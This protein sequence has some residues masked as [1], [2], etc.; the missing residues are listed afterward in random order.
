MAKRADLARLAEGQ[1]LDAVD[2]ATAEAAAL[3]ASRLVSVQPLGNGWLVTAGHTV[4]AVRCG[5]LVVRVRPKLAPLQVLRLLARAHGWA[6]SP[7][8]GTESEWGLGPGADED[9]LTTMLAVLFA[10][11]AS[12]AFA[13]GPARGYR[14]EPRL[15]PVLRGRLNVRDQE[16]RRF[17][18]P[19]PLAVT[20]DEWTTD[21]AENRRLRAAG[22]RLL[23]LPGLPRTTVDRLVWLDRLLASVPLASDPPPWRSTR[24]DVRLHRL[25]H[26]ADLVLAHQAVE[27]R[28]G[29]VELRGC[30][31]SMGTLFEKLVVRLLAEAATAAGPGFGVWGQRSCGLDAADRLTITPDLVVT[32]GSR[33]VAVADARYEL[34]AGGRLT[35]PDAYRL[36]AYCARL[37]LDTGHVLYAS[38][39]PRSELYDVLGAG[40]R[41]VV[42]GIDLRQPV[43]ELARAVH[44]VF[45]KLVRLRPTSA[46][47]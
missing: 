33:A 4:G 39:S 13:S 29:R 24:L 42:H 17:G 35:S 19:T 31:L 40:T 36:I 14:P 8:D 23:A 16:L 37:G 34:P 44:K 28:A 47:A 10:H 43:G 32:A 45:L 26:L 21:T 25:L 18:R 5:D 46:T 20:V 9:D 3:A 2:L 22:H 30:T 41:L 12:T 15:L 7:W 38:G 1:R 11:E 27:Q 6:N